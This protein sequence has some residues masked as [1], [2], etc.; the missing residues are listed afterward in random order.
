MKQLHKVHA[1]P[2][3]KP[4]IIC[5]M[6]FYGEFRG[7][8]SEWRFGTQDNSFIPEERKGIKIIPHYLYFTTH[9]SIQDLSSLMLSENG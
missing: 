9:Q 8:K 1:V 3:E 5:K 7:D 6:E 2:T 4:S